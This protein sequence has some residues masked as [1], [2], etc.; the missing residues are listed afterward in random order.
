M[1][2]LEAYVLLKLT[3]FMLARLL[4]C[5]IE[6]SVSL[7]RSQKLSSIYSAAESYKNSHDISVLIKEV[8]WGF[9]KAF[10]AAHNLDDV[11]SLEL[12]FIGDG[13]ENQIFRH[14][15]T[16]EC[17]VHSQDGISVYGQRIWR[18]VRT[19]FFLS[20]MFALECNLIQSLPYISHSEFYSEQFVLVVVLSSWAP[21]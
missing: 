12:V 13:V 5:E 3:S 10:L 8:M 16:S 7:K 18:S 9:L 2:E 17:N 4:S 6:F 11:F 15:S 14:D 19:L 1:G 21:C 20:D